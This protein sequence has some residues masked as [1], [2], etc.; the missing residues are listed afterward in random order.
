MDFRIYSVKENLINL[1]F[2]QVGLCPPPQMGAQG[3]PATVPSARTK[4]Q[5]Q[6]HAGLG[7]RQSNH[8]DLSLPLA[9]GGGLSGSLWD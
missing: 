7:L 4:Q 3:N 5:G 2:S 9:L 1:G 8:S 6:L